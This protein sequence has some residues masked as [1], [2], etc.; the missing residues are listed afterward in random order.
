MEMDEL[1]KAWKKAQAT[2]EEDKNVAPPK[3]R[4]FDLWLYFYGLYRPKSITP[5]STAMA[6]TAYAIGVASQIRP[7]LFKNNAEYAEKYDELVGM[8][9][10][11]SALL[12][13]AEQKLIDLGYK[14]DGANGY[15][16]K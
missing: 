16:K 7:T 9:R 13:Q 10:N 14:W 11:T 8:V 6:R 3:W 15:V 1:E 5:E 12:Q 4:L 2:Q